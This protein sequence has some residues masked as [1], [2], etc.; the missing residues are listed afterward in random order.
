MEVVVGGDLL[1]L[2][3]EVLLGVVVCSVEFLLLVG[4]FFLEILDIALHALFVFK[5][6]SVD[7]GV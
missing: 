1:F 4:D 3:V 2:A 5:K 7:T 6:L